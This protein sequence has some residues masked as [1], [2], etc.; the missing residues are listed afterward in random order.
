MRSTPCLT[1]SAQPPNVAANG[2]SASIAAR[3][4]ASSVSRRSRRIV[5]CPLPRSVIH[6]ASSRRA[7]SEGSAA[8]FRVGTIVS[9]SRRVRATSASA[10][11][12][13]HDSAW[14]ARAAR[15]PNRKSAAPSNPSRA[16]AEP[17]ER[18]DERRYFGS[19]LLGSSANETPT[20][21]QYA[22]SSVL[23]M[24]SSGRAR[25]RVSRPLQAAMPA[26][27]AMP[28]PRVSRMR[29]VSA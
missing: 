21:R 22:T 6:F 8:K 18:N 12:K 27:P 7:I 13:A 29:I 9:V 10:M 20:A 14:S 2:L 5:A 23:L 1:T 19:L 17:A 25:V 3:R 15:R 4:R 16:S 26:R 28:D 24:S 11:V